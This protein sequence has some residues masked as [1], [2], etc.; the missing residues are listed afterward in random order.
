MDYTLFTDYA[1]IPKNKRVTIIDVPF[2]D[3]DEICPSGIVNVFDYYRGKIVSGTLE[4]Y[5]IGE[6]SDRILKYPYKEDVFLHEDAKQTHDIIMESVGIYRKANGDPQEIKKIMN[7]LERIRED[8]EYL[9][10][11]TWIIKTLVIPGSFTFCYLT[12][13][14]MNVRINLSFI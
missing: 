8:Y 10:D 6:I 11:M 13:F 7:E 14:D 12:K 1:T 2:E 3:K 4:K 9:D 5:D